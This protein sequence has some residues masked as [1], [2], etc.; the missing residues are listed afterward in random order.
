MKRIILLLMISAI[1]LSITF[2]L[3]AQEAK[4]KSFKKK[5]GTEKSF[6][7]PAKQSKIKVV[8][9][10]LEFNIVGNVVDLYKAM[11]ETGDCAVDQAQA[12]KL[13]QE[14]APLAVKVDG[15][16]YI[17]FLEDGMYAGQH[18]AE[19]AGGKVGIAGK[20]KVVNGLNVIHAMAIEEY[21]EA[22]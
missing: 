22:K 14:G 21:K 5:E 20:M 16:L 11:M 19:L 3:G 17:V 7:K 8:E 9:N 1:G 6:K 18:L 10:K 13:F 2:N 12:T 15:K 4:E